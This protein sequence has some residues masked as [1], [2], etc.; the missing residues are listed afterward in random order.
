MGYGT[1]VLDIVESSHCQRKGGTMNEVP[2]HDNQGNPVDWNEVLHTWIGTD[3]AAESIGMSL[4][5]VFDA[6]DRKTLR[7]V[8]LGPIHRGR[9]YISP[10]SAR[11][12]E[13]GNTG[14][15]P[16]NSN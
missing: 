3:E 12:Y 13:K 7:A 8:K 9:W 4:K 10:E 14:P 6:I 11:N 2:T 5:A 1:P 15:K 16:E